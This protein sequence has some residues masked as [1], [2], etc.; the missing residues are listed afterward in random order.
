MNERHTLLLAQVM[1]W[2]DTPGGECLAYHTLTFPLSLSLSLSLHTH[3]HA[4]THTHTHAYTCTQAV[5]IGTESCL[6]L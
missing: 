5:E 1:D 3:M 2:L 4:H 6:L